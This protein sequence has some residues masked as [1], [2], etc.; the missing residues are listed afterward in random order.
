[1]AKQKTYKCSY[2]HCKHS[3]PLISEDESPV[4]VGSRYMHEDCAKNQENI[5]AIRD[6]YFNEVSNTV[7]MSQLV[8]V[9]N[10]IIFNKNVDSDYL[11]FALKYALKYKIQI[12]SPYTLHYI[13]DYKRIKDAWQSKIANEKAE[14]IKEKMKISDDEINRISEKN[15]FVFTPSNNQG[16]ANIFGG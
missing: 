3:S 5:T 11:L 16:F 2:K 4:K 6:L 7:V 9:I 13:I 15:T 14:Q 1:M 10:N 12:K 8:N